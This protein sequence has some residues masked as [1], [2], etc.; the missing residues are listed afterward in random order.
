M[1]GQTEVVY[2]T[3]PAFYRA[4]CASCET[5]RE[6][7]S[8]LS[9]HMH[10]PVTTSRA[11]DW[12]VSLYKPGRRVFARIYVTCSLCDVTRAASSLCPRSPL[13]HDPA[14]EATREQDP[15]QRKYVCK[16]CTRRQVA[17][18]KRSVLAQRARRQHRMLRVGG[19]HSGHGR[20]RACA[21][22]ARTTPSSSSLRVPYVYVHA[23]S[24]HNLSRSRHWPGISQRSSCALITHA[25]ACMAAAR[26]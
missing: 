25:P 22:A 9:M 21:R 1:H 5:K 3:T 18:E 12:I 2:F 13:A 6:R 20:P 10:N 24:L 23:A 19:F 16:N 15:E 14:D 7:E 26:G 17:H 11:N 8:L 4:L